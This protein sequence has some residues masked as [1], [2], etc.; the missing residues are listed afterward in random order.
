M[1]V[2]LTDSIDFSQFVEKEIS[3]KVT[4]VCG[5]F[6]VATCLYYIATLV[7]ENQK[8]KWLKQSYTDLKKNY[9]G[10]FDCKDLDEAF[11]HDKPMENVEKQYKSIRKKISALWIGLILALGIFTGVLVWQGN[12]M[13]IQE[14]AQIEEPVPSEVNIDQRQE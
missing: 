9:D 6:T 12:Y 14:R 3:P 5:V 2:L 10:V 8:W 13:A 4:A 11:N 7:M 1:T